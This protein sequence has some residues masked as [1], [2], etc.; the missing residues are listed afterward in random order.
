MTGDRDFLYII[1]ICQLGLGI[2]P[3]LDFHTLPASTHYSQRINDRSGLLMSV[4]KVHR[5]Y[6]LFDRL[7]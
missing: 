5:P 6:P 4:V 2:E 1:I 7:D 3:Y